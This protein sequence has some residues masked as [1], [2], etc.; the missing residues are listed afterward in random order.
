MTHILEYWASQVAPQFEQPTILL[1]SCHSL[2]VINYHQRYLQGFL[3]LTHSVFPWMKK[4]QAGSSSV[5]EPFY[6]P[7]S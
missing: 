7:Y 6:V 2:L 3:S 1:E 4:I 5:A